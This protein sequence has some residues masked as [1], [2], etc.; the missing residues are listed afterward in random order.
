MCIISRNLDLKEYQE[1]SIYKRKVPGSRGKKII[2]FGGR[3][4]YKF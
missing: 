2:N 3:L 4:D 1:A